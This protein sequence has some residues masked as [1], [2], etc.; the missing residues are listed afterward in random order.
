MSEIQGNQ[1]WNKS[2]IYAFASNFLMMFAFYLL[3]PTLP[4]YLNDFF[5]SDKT[6]IGIVMSIYIV[7]AVAIRPFSGYFID[8]LDRKKLYIVAYV[9]FTCLFALYNLA[10][11]LGWFVFLRILHG[12]T[13]GIT[14]TAGNTLAIDVL[15]SNRRGEGIGYYGLSTNIAM[16]LGPMAGLFL[17]NFFNFSFIFWFAFIAGTLGLGISFLIHAPHHKIVKHEPMSLDRFILVKAIPSGLNLLLIALS[18]GLIISFGAVFG[19]EIN[20]SNTGIFYTLLA[21]GIFIARF[22]SGKFLNSGK[23]KPIGIISISLLAI[24]FAL[25][26]QTTH[27]W[28]YYTLAILIGLGFGMLTP[29]FQT[30][31]VN[32]APHNKRGTANSTFFTSLDL[33]VGG[34]M[35]LGG[36]I[37]EIWNLNTAFAIVAV[38]NLMGLI[39]F[40]RYSI[41]LY[42]RNK[43]V[44]NH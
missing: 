1:L 31:T 30:M 20:V 44:D 18:Y 8:T 2:F 38:A 22:S 17:M 16:A 15:P 27:A 42:N 41:P 28:E 29:A 37:S 5:Q 25:L 12:F 33:G 43:A 26:A 3:I 6:T 40:S 10:T 36:Q 9:A 4:F 32:M 13:F 39:L 7:A 35:L 14:T 19:K 11:A 23:F 24:S 21:S 34:G